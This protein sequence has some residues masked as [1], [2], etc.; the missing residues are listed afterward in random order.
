[1]K[2]F[3]IGLTMLFCSCCMVCGKSQGVWKMPKIAVVA[4]TFVDVLLE[5]GQQDAIREILVSVLVNTKQCSVLERALIDK[6]LQEQTFCQ[7]CMVDDNDV[8]A[9]GKLAGAEKVLVTVL[10][11]VSKKQLLFIVKLLNGETAKVE[12]QKYRYVKDIDDLFQQ[13]KPAIWDLL[14]FNGV[15]EGERKAG[16]PHGQGVMEYRGGEATYSGAWVNGVRQGFGVLEWWTCGWTSNGASYSYTARYEGEWLNDKRHGKG[17]ETTYN[18]IFDGEWKGGKKWKGVLKYSN[19]NR[20]EGEFVGNKPASGVLKMANGDQYYGEFDYD[21]GTVYEGGGSEGYKG[22][23][24]YAN[25]DKFEGKFLGY[26]YFN[27]CY[28]YYDGVMHGIMHYMNGE[29]YEGELFR[30]KRSTKNMSPY[31]GVMYYSNGDTYKGSWG[32]DKREGRGIL[33]RNDGS[34]YD[35]E[36]RD[37]LQHGRGKEYSPKGAMVRDGYWK[38]GKK[39][40]K[41]NYNR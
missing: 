11:K 26:Y 24:L 34:R 29:K 16:K 23:M 14:D 18:S 7:S 38:Y 2:R 25:G 28:H 36:W 5:K 30:G 8:L 41:R 19:G 4:P 1:M 31:Q 40:S 3:M 39:V 10:S 37:D 15:Y 32:N 22:V 9:L 13:I 35:G 12:S 27:G 33:F 20:F 6:I 17:V 21:K